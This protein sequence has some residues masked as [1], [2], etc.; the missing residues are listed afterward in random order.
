MVTDLIYFCK[1]RDIL[2]SNLVFN[3]KRALALSE[4]LIYYQLGESWINL[5]L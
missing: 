3:P 5:C 4:Y 2:E 1:A